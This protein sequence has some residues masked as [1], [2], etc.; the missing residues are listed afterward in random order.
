MVL[1]T[2]IA[3]NVEV[4]SVAVAT[5]TLKTSVIYIYE[6]IGDLGV[7]VSRYSVNFAKVLS[8]HENLENRVSIIMYPFV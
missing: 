8:L 5:E 3:D 2:R 1:F 7:M 6:V 4:L